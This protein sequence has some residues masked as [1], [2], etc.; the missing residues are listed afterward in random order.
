[1]KQKPGTHLSVPARFNNL[2]FWIYC[3][4]AIGGMY[5]NLSFRRRGLSGVEIGAIGAVISITSVVITPLLGIRFDSAA[6]RPAFM[7]VLFLL[8]GA[9]FSAL[10][11]NLPFFILLIL[12]AAMSACWSPLVPM[13]DSISF[14]ARISGT[15]PRG[16]GGYR[17]W[18]SV[19]FAAASVAVGFAAGRAGLGVM[20][21]AYFACALL[22]SLLAA[23]IPSDAAPAPK[24]RLGT[25]SIKALLK[26]ENLGMFLAF[27][28]FNSV[29]SSACW[30]FRSIYLDSVGVPEH[31]I[32]LLA[33]LPILAEVIIFTLGNR[34]L[35]RW[36]TGALISTGALMS[37]SRWW[38]MSSTDR[39]PLLYLVEIL[40]GSGWALFF[41]GAIALVQNEVP[42]SQRGTAQILFF[43]SAGG[44][45]AATGAY[46]GGWIFDHLGVVSVLRIGSAVSAAA[47]AF[48][49]L[50]V[51]ET[52]RYRAGALPPPPE[53]PA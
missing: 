27:Y 35:S 30:S 11:L 44:V 24:A 23:G 15:T 6:N 13:L 39:I 4:V 21:P 2:Y 25:D 45:G 46:L 1:M 50:F 43:N 29:G 36:G 41:T 18:G 22:L 28:V 26:H 14:G 9:F 17:R 48:Q 3:M 12:A 20:F 34:I 8:A 52:A 31:H 5:L 33:I 16:Y 53:T 51:R 40:A 19:G 10:G 37:A 42:Q 47:V 38:L 32:G 7:S 49:F